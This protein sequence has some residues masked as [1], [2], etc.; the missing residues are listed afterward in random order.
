MCVVHL[1]S[2]VRCTVTQYSLYFKHVIVRV[3]HLMDGMEYASVGWYFP[4]LI[5]NIS[6]MLPQIFHISLMLSTKCMSGAMCRGFSNLGTA[7]SNCYN[8]AVPKMHQAF[9]A[10]EEFEKEV[11]NIVLWFSLLLPPIWVF[12]QGRP[13]HSQLLFSP[14]PLLNQDNT[15]FL[16]ARA[17]VSTPS[18]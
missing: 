1:Y 5:P 16:D 10:S 4:I 8:G 13:F 14:P 6:L 2:T 12:K 11:C 15:N 18:L 3:W 17:G 7:P 9:V